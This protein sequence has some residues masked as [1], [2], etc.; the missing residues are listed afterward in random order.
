MRP[1]FVNDPAA[2][3]KCT[4]L[5][6]LSCGTEDSRIDSTREAVREL[7]AKGV[8]VLLKLMLAN[9]SGEYGDAR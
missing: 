8:D 6:F 2:T 9:M 3:N 7:Q 5:F 4:Q 1:G